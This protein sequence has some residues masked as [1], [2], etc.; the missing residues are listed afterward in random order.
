MK[1]IR[2]YFAGSE[3]CMEGGI[4]R[5]QRHGVDV[6]NRLV[7]FF[8]PREFRQW[9][10]F[11]G[12]KPGHVILD[13]GAFS[14]WNNGHYIDF[15]HYIHFCQECIK[16]GADY[17]KEVRV[18]NLDVIPGT[19]G[20]T[21]ALLRFDSADENRNI[22]N[23]AASQ[24]Y[25]NLLRMRDAGITPIHV[26]HQGEDWQ[27]LHKMACV[28]DYIGISPANDMPLFSRLQ[29]MASVFE[30][31]QRNYIDVKTHGFAVWMLPVLKNLPFTSCDAATA[32]LL[33][34]FGGCYYPEGGFAHPDYSQPP[35]AWHPSDRKAIEGFGI[36]TPLKTAVL[37]EDGYSFEDLKT[38]Q[39]R[40]EINI[41][42]MLGLQEWIDRYRAEHDFEVPRT[43]L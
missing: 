15:R 4:R 9:C 7:S 16:M 39:T 6:E 42:Y 3:S 30:Y 29:W 5:V 2:L 19:A 22:I 33:A 43:L 11:T 8:Y 18:V 28:T 40:T 14:A 32:V 10:E 31:M 23:I 24:G 26:F 34:A 38:W 21:Q 12:D 41:R 25:E 36:Y 17:N 13:S 37:R 35:H 1:P 20:Q 27:W